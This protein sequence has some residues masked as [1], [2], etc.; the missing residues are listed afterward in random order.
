[1][2]FDITERYLDGVVLLS[3]GYNASPWG[4]CKAHGV[5]LA[6]FL[7]EL[8]EGKLEAYRTVEG[9]RFHDGRVHPMAIMMGVVETREGTMNIYR[10]ND[11]VGVEGEPVYVVVVEA[12]GINYFGFTITPDEDFSD[13]GFFSA[14]GIDDLKGAAELLAGIDY[15]AEGL[16]TQA[17]AYAEESN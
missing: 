3:A 14:F 7:P 17:E 10:L 11:Y 13:Y 4:L 15:E 2:K 6:K 12:D 9:V 1:M 5:E 16:V 8:A